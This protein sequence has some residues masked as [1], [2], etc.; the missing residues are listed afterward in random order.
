MTLAMEAAQYA[1]ARVT[2]HYER[3]ITSG[4]QCISAY[5]NG[6]CSASG[7]TANCRG[8]ND[9]IEYDTF[10]MHTVAVSRTCD[11]RRSILE[12]YVYFCVLY[13]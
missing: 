9:L 13:L 7:I 3:L 4:I 11:R 5:E 2:G 1:R 10:H 12:R 8:L 6:I